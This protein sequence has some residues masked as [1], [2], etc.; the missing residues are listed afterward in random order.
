MR[1]LQSQRAEYRDARAPR[2]AG[3]SRGVGAKS[4]AHRAS[5]KRC[6]GIRTGFRDA[7]SDAKVASCS[8]FHALTG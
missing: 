7:A 8:F 6:D 1:V 4:H 5:R 3:A 2:D